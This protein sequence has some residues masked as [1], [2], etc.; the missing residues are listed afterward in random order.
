MHL[1]LR[2]DSM[3][4]TIVADYAERAFARTPWLLPVRGTLITVQV[5]HGDYAAGIA[6]AMAVAE[7]YHK[8]HHPLAQKNRAASLAT[9]AVGYQSRRCTKHP[10]LHKLHSPATLPMIPSAPSKIDN[11]YP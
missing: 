2:H 3:A 8:L 4:L 11:H 1:M 6:L 7:E 10:H 9:V 5:A